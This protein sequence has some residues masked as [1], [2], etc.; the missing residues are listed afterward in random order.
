MKQNTF[1]KHAQLLSAVSVLVYLRQPL[2]K[3]Q[4][5]KQAQSNP[6]KQKSYHSTV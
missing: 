2:H 6:Q 4:A 5:S 1:T 3:R